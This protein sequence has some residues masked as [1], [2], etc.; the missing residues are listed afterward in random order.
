MD[1]WDVQN[2]FQCSDDGCSEGIPQT[3]VPIYT[4]D[5]AAER[6]NLQVNSTSWYLRDNDNGDVDF[7]VSWNNQG[8]NVY[9]YQNTEEVWAY[10]T[11]MHES[12]SD[13]YFAT[14]PAN[15][16]DKTCDEATGGY[17]YISW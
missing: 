2:N 5:S 11:N 3:Q 9:F 4:T 17:W 6:L 10:C 8:N 13:L 12:K 7:A 14:A 16:G 1:A 15:S